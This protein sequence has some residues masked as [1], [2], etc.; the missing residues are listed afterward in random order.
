MLQVRAE[1]NARIEAAVHSLN[2]KYED[3]NTD[4]IF[5]ADIGNAFNSLN[6]QSFLHNTV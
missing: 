2:M 4:G 5:L 6:R 1:Q 3:E